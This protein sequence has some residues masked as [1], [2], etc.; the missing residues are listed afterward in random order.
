MQTIVVD[1]EIRDKIIKFKLAWIES[2][3]IIRLIVSKEKH[4]KNTKA[5][6]LYQHL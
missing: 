1:R 4:K 5:R 3:K 2:E 6:K